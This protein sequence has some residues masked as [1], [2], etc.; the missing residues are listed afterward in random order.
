MEDQLLTGIELPRNHGQ[1]RDVSEDTARDHFRA[2][3]LEQGG[4]APGIFDFPRA[5]STE[6]LG[7]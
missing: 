5:V 1:D 4:I 2:Q 6:G 7:S 3:V